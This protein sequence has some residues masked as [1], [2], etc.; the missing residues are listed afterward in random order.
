[1]ASDS[2]PIDVKNLFVGEE[3]IVYCANFE[4]DPSVAGGATISNP[5]LTLAN[6]KVTM[7]VAPSVVSADFVQYDKYGKE[8]GRVPA[9]KGVKFSVT[10]ASVGQCRGLVK[11]DASDGESPEVAVNFVVS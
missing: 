9:G 5:T 1:M 4:S 11:V 2:R 7:A 8:V 10:A 3:A 6:G